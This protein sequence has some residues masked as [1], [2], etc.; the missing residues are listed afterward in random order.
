MAD[1]TTT[2]Y[3]LTKPEVGASQDTWGGKLNTNFDTLDN[4]LDGTTQISPK[5]DI[6]G[7]SGDFKINGVSVTATAAEL[8]KLDGA[9]L[10]VAAVTATAA[11][12]NKLD[13][14]TATTAELNVLDG[15]TSTT[16]ELNI[17]DGVTSTASE[18]NKLDGVTLALS[19]LNGMTGGIKDED[20]MASNSA[21]ALATQQSIKAYVDSAIPSIKAGG[22]TASSGTD[23]SVTTGST[24]K[25][26]V[27]GFGGRKAN[28]GNFGTQTLQL[29]KGASVLR[30]D[31]FKTMEYDSRES[32]GSTMLVY[33]YT[34]SANT[35]YS[36]FDLYWS[37][38]SGSEDTLSYFYVGF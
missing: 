18:I 28:Y 1:T 14:V 20:N 3:G 29:R 24:G 6:D 25:V 30:E 37:S 15:I 38:A 13:G 32:S 4:L 11:E 35:T 27:V 9:V 7:V 2:T 17:L 19:F 31:S 33:V 5:V 34:G 12:V 10:D 8:N 26:L 22:S 16:A 23:F 36:D 21:S